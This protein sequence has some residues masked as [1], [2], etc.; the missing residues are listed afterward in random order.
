MAFAQVNDELGDTAASAARGAFLLDEVVVT[1]SGGEQ[2]VVEAPATVTVIDKAEIE[3]RPGDSVTDLIGRTAGVS[4]QQSRKLKSDEIT[5]RGLGESYVAVMVNGKPM[6]ASQ[7]ASYNGWGA[8]LKTS[9]LPPASMIERV[10]V[11]RGPMSS[12]YGTSAMGG[13]V[14]V[15]TKKSLDSWGGEVTAGY[16]A[17]EDDDSGAEKLLRYYVSGPL[18]QDRLNLSLFG[19]LNYRDEDNFIDGFPEGEV[20]NHGAKINWVLTDRQDLEFEYSQSALDFKTTTATREQG[21]YNDTARTY[22]ALT[23]TIG[24]NDNVDT[25][26]FLTHEKVDIDN[27]YL[28]PA[29][30]DEAVFS[31][32][33]LTYF[34]SQTSFGWG[35]H[36]STVGLD[37]R[38]ES[39]SHTPLRFNGS[40][41]TNLKR[42]QYGVFAENVWQMSSDFIL[43][44]GLRF[45]D[46]EHYG[47]NI[48]PRVYGV[49]HL[50]DQLTLRGG[51]S[52]GFLTPELKQADS[53]IVEDA[54]RS[55]G[56]D[57]GNTD[58]KPEET[59]SFEVGIAY[60]SE[61]DIQTTLTLFHTKFNNKI[62][63]EFVCLT[64][65]GEAPSCTYNGETREFIR[66]YV[67]VD[68]A[69][70]QG[71]EMTLDI[72]LGAFDVGF[73]YTYSESEYLTG[74]KK[75]EPFNEVP[76]HLANVRLGW[77]FSNAIDI[78][79][80]AQHRSYLPEQPELTTADIGL[81]YQFTKNVRLNGTI[82]NLFNKRVV[83]GIDG[84]TNDGRRLFVSM[85]ASF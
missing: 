17:H 76:K 79:M 83:D 48:T 85:T 71:V 1:A 42:W 56:F 52:A 54:G 65:E 37:Y 45:D 50:N 59:D 55:L 43:T 46:N 61:T 24:W 60:L 13:V 51:Y 82:Y 68:E 77:K 63:K 25:V 35:A 64:P 74:S 36:D 44:M 16:T 7:D 26:S 47:S 38:D 70:L 39:T 34:K 19:D 75:G 67:N 66:E 4:L 10:E 15:I 2:L 49:Y 12:L 18:I 40:L 3:A 30:A 57:K 27:G 33:S 69:E 20:V 32:Y 8:G 81:N 80:G 21:Q 73:N 5:I 14:N 84:I 28:D 9:F 58:L 23:H 22:A 6:G 53:G 31:D 72:P 62:D 41:N 78:W 29:R 11:V